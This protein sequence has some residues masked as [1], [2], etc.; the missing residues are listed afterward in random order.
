MFRILQIFRIFENYLN[1]SE[2]L[3]HSNIVKG[4][5]LMTA[6]SILIL[7]NAKDELSNIFFNFI[8]NVLIEFIK[9]TNNYTNIYLRQISCLCLDELETEYPGLLFSL[10]GKKFLDIV[11]LKDSPKGDKKSDIGKSVK[12]VRTN[13]SEIPILDNKIELESKYLTTNIFH[14]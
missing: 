9:N 14:F 2:Y 4:Q 3:N 7:I 6:T 8:D 12:S 11:D 5:I 1:D 13:K 10:M